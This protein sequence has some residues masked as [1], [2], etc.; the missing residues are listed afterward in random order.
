MFVTTKRL[1]IASLVL[2]LCGCGE[3]SS[4]KRVVAG[5]PKPAADV[6][7]IA[8]TVSSGVGVVGRTQGTGNGAG[9]MVMEELHNS[10][11]GQIQHAIMM[12]RLQIWP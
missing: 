4:S 12:G 2:V 6:S 5:A 9:V 11:A 7:Q 8:N 10:R 3:D 1:L